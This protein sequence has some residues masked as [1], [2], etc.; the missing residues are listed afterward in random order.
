MLACV[1]ARER[2]HVYMYM[3]VYPTHSYTHSLSH[4][5]PYASVRGMCLYMRTYTHNTHMLVYG[6]THTTHTAK[7]CSQRSSLGENA[8]KHKKKQPHSTVRGVAL[9]ETLASLAHVPLQ[10]LNLLLL[11]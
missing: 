6:Y 9:A 8:K 3:Y 1:R 4:T 7:F 10:V 2:V 11:C 5:Q